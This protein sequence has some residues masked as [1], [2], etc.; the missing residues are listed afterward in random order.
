MS[1]AVFKCGSMEVDEI[2]SR[3]STSLS[4]SNK[5]VTCE[6]I[7]DGGV[8]FYLEEPPQPRQQVGYLATQGRFVLW[9]IRLAV[10]AKDFVTEIPGY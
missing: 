8:D 10:L 7:C 1:Q 9:D 3:L 2:A 5:K 4:T 6:K